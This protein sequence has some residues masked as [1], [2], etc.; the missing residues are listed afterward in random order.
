MT[1]IQLISDT[2]ENF[3]DFIPNSRADLIIHAGD[4]FKCGPSPLDSIM[5]F[6][7]VCR[8]QGK[9]HLIV[10]GN[11]DF[12]MNTIESDSLYDKLKHEGVNCLRSGVKFQ[13]NDWT[14]VGGTLWSDVSD[15]EN[16]IKENAARIMV[17]LFISD[18]RAICKK[19]YSGKIELS[20]IRES[21]QEHIEWIEKFR[22]SEKVFVMT[23]FQ[24]TRKTVD[25]RF[26]GN[27][28]NPYFMNEIDL[29]GFKHWA[30]GHCHRTI[31][32]TVIDGC[33]V[34]CNAFGYSDRYGNSENPDFDPQYLIELE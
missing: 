1:I 14:F 10:L 25:S 30:W 32:N 18:F 5:D 34:Y 33:S 21:Y 27:N 22:N 31:K 26:A 16:P 17:P 11:H 3:G 6:I 20:D 2:H 24:P 29:T 8:K 12:Y 9:D 15:R 28:L 13:Y 4:F 7:N 19:D 23:H